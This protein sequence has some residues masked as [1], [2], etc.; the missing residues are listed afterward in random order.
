MPLKPNTGTSN[1][2]T[3]PIGVVVVTHG[4]LALELVRT[5]R[6]VLGTLPNVV[7]VAIEGTESTLRIK[8][9]IAE[10]MKRVDRG[11][12]III[13]TDMMGGTATNLSLEVA[14][15]ARGEVLAGV[16]L[17]ILIKLGTLRIG[18]ARHLVR[19][20]RIHGQRQIIEA[21][22]L[23]EKRLKRSNQVQQ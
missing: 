7:A 18:E 1:A 22:P 13:L 5:A 2:K 4:G 20:L 23:L 17:P 16:N 3:R 10:A 19:T 9:K 21:S 6:S 11:S 15:R 8:K 12:G 14:R